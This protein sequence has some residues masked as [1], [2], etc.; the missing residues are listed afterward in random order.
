MP[1]QFIRP[2][3]SRLFEASKEDREQT[4]R[5]VRDSRQMRPAYLVMLVLACLVALFGLLGNSPAVVIGA[6]LISPLMSPF[7][8]AGLALAVGD[9]PLGRAAIKTIALSVLAAIS[10]SALAVAASPLKEATPEILVRT[11]P[12]LLDLGIAFFSGFAGTFTLVSRKGGTTIPGVAIATAVMPPLCVVGFGVNRLNWT[13]AAGAMSLFLTNLAAIIIS[14]ATVFLLASYRASDRPASE[15]EQRSA[16]VRL[17]VSFAVLLVL[18]IPLASALVRAAEAARL[19]ES[20]RAALSRAI[21]RD[22]DRARVASGWTV[23]PAADGGVEVDAT[24]RTVA[25]FNRAE[26][27]GLER[28]LAEQLGRPVALRLEQIRVQEGGLDPEPAAATALGPA[29][30]ASAT[31]P[32]LDETVAAY[33]EGAD[34]AVAALGATLDRYLVGADEK[35]VRRLEIYAFS[36][37]A[38]SADRLDSA[39]RAAA[40]WARRRETAAEGVP[41]IVIH[42]R[43]RQPVELALVPDARTRRQSLEPI[44]SELDRIRAFLTADPSL[45]LRLAIAGGAEA[46][47]EALAASV[48]A[49]LGV[50]PTRVAGPDADSRDPGSIVDVRITI[51]DAPET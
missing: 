41:E 30:L 12:N 34:L 49:A 1:R 18:S 47:R 22:P 7:L 15:G 24:A 45:R 38:P 44:R 11:A 3:L 42:A 51:A 5:E 26:V 27:E 9:W 19:R 33:R 4:Y 17:A 8:S 37:S 36:E 10:I 48:V 29:A 6:M 43:P 14:A 16:A 2:L 13:I 20:V 28:A 46:A 21:E 32:S 50:D 25:Y 35:G 40:E 31:T 23:R 39:V